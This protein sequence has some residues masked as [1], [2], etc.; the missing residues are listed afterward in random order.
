M[1]N[2]NT[3]L[4]IPFRDYCQKLALALTSNPKTALHSLSLNGN[5]IEDRGMFCNNR[6]KINLKKQSALVEIHIVTKVVEVCHV[7]AQ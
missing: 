3:L 1:L 6:I 5:A 7:S 2:T 4:Q